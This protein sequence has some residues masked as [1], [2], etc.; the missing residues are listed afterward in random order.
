MESSDFKVVPQ[1]AAIRI[2]YQPGVAWA[3]AGQERTKNSRKGKTG[4]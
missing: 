4:V 3:L 2:P 1:V